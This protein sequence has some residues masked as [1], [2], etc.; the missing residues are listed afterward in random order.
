MVSDIVWL[1]QVLAY[2]DPF[3]KCVPEEY[4][5]NNIIMWPDLE[6]VEAVTNSKNRYVGI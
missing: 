1:Q 4:I 5:H 2:L 6:V 3:F